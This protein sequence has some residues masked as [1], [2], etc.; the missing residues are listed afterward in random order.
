MQSLDIISVNLWNI[1]VS[2]CNLLIIYLI[3]KKVLF[4]PVRKL[5]AS[6]QAEIAKQYE[7]ADEAERR[8][9]ESKAEWDEKMKNADTEAD[10]IVRDATETASHRAEKIIEEAN[11]QAELIKARAVN[12]A[13]LT[14]KQA[15]ESIKQEIVGVSSAIAEKVLEREIDVND[16]RALIDSFINGVGEDS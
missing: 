9:L 6:R 12:A 16:H 11:A 3:V 7:A 14:K 1:I 2:L 8:A 5:I 13:E 4:G 15:E 10:S